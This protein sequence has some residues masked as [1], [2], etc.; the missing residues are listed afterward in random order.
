MNE[1]AKELLAW[2]VRGVG[3]EE[4]PFGDLLDGRPV[5]LTFLR[6]FG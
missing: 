2:K 4:G 1:L 3:F 5:L 6:Q